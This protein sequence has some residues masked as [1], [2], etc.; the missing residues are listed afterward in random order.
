M[1]FSCRLSTHLSNSKLKPFIFTMIFGI[2]GLTADLLLLFY[3][4][5]TFSYIFLS[6]DFSNWLKSFSVLLLGLHCFLVITF[7]ESS[8]E[9]ASDHQTLSWCI[10]NLICLS[11]WI[12]AMIFWSNYFMI[13]HCNYCTHFSF[14]LLT[15]G[16]LLLDHC[17]HLKCP[18][19]GVL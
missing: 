7:K 14:C 11:F 12:I 13:F 9:N 18:F 8:L 17:S 1:N 19:S 5:L 15:L 3:F 2:S 16:L 4:C 10:P 6:L